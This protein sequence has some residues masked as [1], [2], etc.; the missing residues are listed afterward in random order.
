[1]KLIKLEKYEIY[2][3]LHMYGAQVNVYYLQGKGFIDA[4]GEFSDDKE[5]ITNIEKFLENSIDTRTEKQKQGIEIFDPLNDCYLRIIGEIEVPKEDMNEF[6]R[7]NRE[8][9]IARGKREQKLK[10]LTDK[11]L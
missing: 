11:I 6:F 10:S 7:I 9:N 4:K 8:Y 2:D 5:E 1:M 3:S